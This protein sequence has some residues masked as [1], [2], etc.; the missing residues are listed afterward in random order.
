MKEHP[1]LKGYLISNDGR[2]F[3]CHKKRSR[4]T[5][6]I[7]NYIDYN[8]PVE[9]KF[10]P[11]PNGYV[12]VRGKRL[13]RLVAQLYIPNPYNLPEV[14]HIDEDKTN[15]KVS[16][17][18]WCTRQ[19]NA[20]HSLSKTHVVENIKTGEIFEVFNLKKW[21]VNNNLSP[22]SMQETIHQ[23]RRKQHKGYRILKREG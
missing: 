6:K 4:G 20:E 5:R 12:Y 18:E 13:H 2:V 21:C 8:D 10:K 1:D 22:G 23:K 17:L 15:N 7:E 14:N 16:N 11:H 3:S 9:K 19:K